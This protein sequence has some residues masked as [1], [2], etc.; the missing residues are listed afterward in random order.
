MSKIGIRGSYPLGGRVG[1]IQRKGR[2]KISDEMCS[3]G[4]RATM[5]APELCVFLSHELTFDVFSV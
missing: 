4:N 2:K 5:K 3:P 1:D